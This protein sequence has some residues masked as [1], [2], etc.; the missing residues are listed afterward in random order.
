MSS[1]VENVYNNVISGRII[2]PNVLCD[3]TVVSHVMVVMRLTRAEPVIFEVRCRLE[4]RAM[5]HT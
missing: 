1:D 2:V 4:E 5:G 3:V